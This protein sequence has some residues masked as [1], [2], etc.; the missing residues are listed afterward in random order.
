M[1]CELVWGGVM[2]RAMRTEA[3]VREAVWS[4]IEVRGADECWPW[5]GAATTQGYGRLKHGEKFEYPHRYVFLETHGFLPL[6]VRH[7]QAKFT[8]AEIA[9]VRRLRAAGLSARALAARFGM[10]PQ[11]VRQVVRGARRT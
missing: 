5:M 8:D 3:E 2:P 1:T 6:V 7:G 9:E 11:H 10:T 4:R